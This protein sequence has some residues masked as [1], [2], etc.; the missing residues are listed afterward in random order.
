MSD[1]WENGEW[2]EEIFSEHNEVFHKSM[3]DTLLSLPQ[4]HLYGSGYLQ[5]S[6]S[7]N[8]VHTFLHSP[9]SISDAK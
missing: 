8:Q 5:A 7:R 2:I 6:N 3:Q 4:I 9:T 1:R